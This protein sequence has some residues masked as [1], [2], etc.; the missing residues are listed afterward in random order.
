VVSFITNLG[1]HGVLAF[2]SLLVRL[3]YSERWSLARQVLE[4]LYVALVMFLGE[5]GAFGLEAL[6]SDCGVRC[7]HP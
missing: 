6:F 5:Y 4:G 3:Q 1:Y 2:L 7:K